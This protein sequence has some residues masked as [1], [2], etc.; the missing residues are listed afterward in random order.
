ML[1]FSL[2]RNLENVKSSAETNISHLD[3]LSDYNKNDKEKETL[4]SSRCGDVNMNI[5]K[6]RFIYRMNKYNDI[7]VDI[8]NLESYHFNYCVVNFLSIILITRMKYFI[9]LFIRILSSK[10]KD[11]IIYQL[12]QNTL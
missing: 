1:K 6:K 2:I 7:Q 8:R 10:I 3:E 4:T 5:I 9:K 12:W 11:G